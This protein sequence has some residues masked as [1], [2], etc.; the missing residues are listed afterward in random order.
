[1]LITNFAGGEISKNLY[2]RVDLP[3]YTN[4]VSRMENFEIMPTGGVF[5]RAGTKRIGKLKGKCRL[6]P[7]IVNDSLSFIFEIGNEYIRI[8]KNGE[9][10]LLGGIPLEFKS[11]DDLPLFLLSEL[12]EIQYAQTHDSV[13]FAH[14]HHKPCR[15][16]WLGGDVFTFEILSITGNAHKI[17]FENIEDYPACVAIFNGRL[18]FASSLKEPQKIWASKVFEYTNF[19]YFDTVV[20][21]T[22]QLKSA[23]LKV[24]TASSQKDS[25][26]LINLTK[27]FTDIENI[28]DYY[29]SGNDFI[30][31]GTKV[32]SCTSDTMK[33]SN[34]IAEAKE[35]IV[36]SIHLWKNADMPEA[37]DYEEL[38]I[39][40]DVTTPA[41]TFS[42]EIGSDKNDAIKWLTPSKDLI[43]GTE[44]SEW[45]MGANVSAVNVA[46]LLNSRY[47]VA[48][49]QA[50][51]AGRSIIFIGANGK[52]IQDYYYDYEQR[53]YK[54]IDLTQISSHLFEKE[55]AIDFDFMRGAGLK[56]FATRKDGQVCSLNYDRNNGIV[57]WSRIILG[58]GEIRN[59]LCASGYEGSDEVYFSVERKGEFYLEKLTNANDD[60]AIFLDSYSEYSLDT[61]LDEYEDEAI[62]Y[63]KE[64][65]I[66]FLKNEI[67]DEFK[68]KDGVIGYEYKSII[69][70]LPVINTATN[71]KKR[72]VSLKM[73]FLDSYFPKI[74][75]VGE[76]DE[77]ITKDEPYSGIIKVPVQGSYDRDVFFKIEAEKNAPCV[78]LSVNAEI[79]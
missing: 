30:P 42:F 71:H 24:F 78:I 10:L 76:K 33:L 41:H 77:L 70:S 37:S 3:F 18:I 40:N 54:A 75:Q 58:N 20:S 38:E 72:I 63:F 7:F 28:E 15:I 32:I 46:V 45:I 8:W 5:R 23:K 64:E 6:I 61:N 49:F 29:I 34:P 73:R 11:T 2:G 69:E 68:N 35:D 17:P 27:D 48:D 74:S 59:T 12:N 1:M 50:V 9:L 55:K 53:S 56:I 62:I 16:K 51:L 4:S 60:K 57:A 79:S 19:T 13:Y 43:I 67:P 14:R 52:S 47:G 65:N 66:S 21:K 44:S 22:K 39:I 26:T 36:L 31:N 25:D